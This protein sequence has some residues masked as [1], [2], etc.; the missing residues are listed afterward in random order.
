LGPCVDAHSVST[1]ATHMRLLLK[2]VVFL[3]ILQAPLQHDYAFITMETVDD[4][5]LSFD[6][7]EFDCL[8]TRVS[9]SPRQSTLHDD[10]WRCPA[11]WEKLRLVI[12]S[13]HDR[14][15]LMP[16][17]CCC[18]QATRFQNDF[19]CCIIFIVFLGMVYFVVVPIILIFIIVASFF[20][21]LFFMSSASS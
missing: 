17:G 1:D 6:P 8:P 12:M 14:I 7:V 9:L 20:S 4:N 19:F 3:R 21:F 13:P 5:A 16:C 11:V 10:R 2:I 15:N 18:G